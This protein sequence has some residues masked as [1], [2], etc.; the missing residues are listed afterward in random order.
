MFESIEEALFLVFRDARTIEPWRA[1]KL[2]IDVIEC[3]IEAAQDYESEE[4]QLME[5]MLEKLK[6]TEL[7]DIPLIIDAM[8]MGLLEGLNKVN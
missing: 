6:D 4:V 2:L 7:E 5:R 3:V 1:K 8:E